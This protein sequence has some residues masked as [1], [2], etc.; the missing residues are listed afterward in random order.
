MIYCEFDSVNIIFTEI[1][2]NINKQKFSKSIL[3]LMIDSD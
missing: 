2:C 3:S 1:V